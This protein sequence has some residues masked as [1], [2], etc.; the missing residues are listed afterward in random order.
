MF[1]R[2]V[3]QA[4]KR[5][6]GGGVKYEKE[7]IQLVKL[8]VHKIASHIEQGLIRDAKTI[9]ALQWFMLHFK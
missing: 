7:D 4:D 3:S 1:Y 5:S 6:Q 2:Q 8:P 9:I